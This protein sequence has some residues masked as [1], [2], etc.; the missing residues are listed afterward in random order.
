MTSISFSTQFVSMSA[1]VD[2]PNYWSLSWSKS[3]M[4]RHHLFVDFA[5][6]QPSF[7]PLQLKEESTH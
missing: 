7:K 1:V 4:H 3:K 5:V 6:P 2:D